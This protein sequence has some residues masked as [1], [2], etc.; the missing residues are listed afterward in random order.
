MENNK[1]IIIIGPCSV[2]KDSIARILE[3]E[4]DFNFIISTTT[5]PIRPGESWKN[6]YYFIKNEEFVNKINNGEMIEFREYH[7][8]VNN[9]P[10]IWYYGAEKKEV[11][12]DK[13]YVVVLDVVGLIEFKE[14]FGDRVIAFFLNADDEIRKNR[15]INRGDFDESEW[16]IRLQDD[17]RMFTPEVIR[18]CADYTIED[19][20]IPTII[21][22]IIKIIT[23]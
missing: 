1:I 6:P 11:A 10:E 16:N 3:K 7:T 15:C 12:D 13:K 18:E 14:V 2:G 21:N 8:I 20:E 4:Y 9:V 22:K 19:L 5:R 17:K 23:Q